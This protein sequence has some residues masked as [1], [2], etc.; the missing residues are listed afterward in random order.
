MSV[1]LMCCW[2]DLLVLYCFIC[3]QMLPVFFFFDVFCAFFVVLG[4]L[5]GFMAFCAPDQNSPGSAQ[6]QRETG[7]SESMVTSL[8]W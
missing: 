8:R 2:F 3:C 4:E 7:D 1:G 5:I 6:W